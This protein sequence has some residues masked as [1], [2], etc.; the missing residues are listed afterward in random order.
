MGL[1]VHA[2]EDHGHL[3]VVPDPAQAPLCRRPF[4]RGLVPDLLYLL[5][6][7]PGKVPAPQ[8]L[9][10]HYGEVLSCRI[11]EPG[12]PRLVMLIEKVVLDLAELPVVRV[13]DLSERV[14]STMEREPGIPDLS[15]CLC[16]V[17]ESGHAEFF[18]FLPALLPE[19]VEQVVI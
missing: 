7:R 11:S 2:R 3:R 12:R 13:H 19:T 18:Q 8:G 6:Y 17:E 10:H 1:V 4:H 5:R 14:E 9:H 16:F 15:L